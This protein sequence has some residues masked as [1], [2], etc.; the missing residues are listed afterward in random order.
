[1][2]SQPAAVDKSENSPLPNTALQAIWSSIF[3]LGHISLGF[4]QL[5]ASL[6]LFVGFETRFTLPA[7]KFAR[8]SPSNML[9]PC[10]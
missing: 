1:M 10:S 5:I 6:P 2:P 3:S 7:Q 9:Q 4:T 8:T